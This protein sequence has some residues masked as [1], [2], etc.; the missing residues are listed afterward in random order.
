MTTMA[1]EAKE[2]ISNWTH[3]W[4]KKVKKHQKEA[5]VYN[6]GLLNFK[7]FRFFPFLYRETEIT[8]PSSAPGATTVTRLSA[9]LEIV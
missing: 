8:V 9:V 6:G 2:I 4:Q 5:T 1:A 7:P 3:P